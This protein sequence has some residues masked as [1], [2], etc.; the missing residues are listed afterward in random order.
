[1][2]KMSAIG[3]IAEIA[4][5]LA[6][7]LFFGVIGPYGTAQEP[8][9]ERYPFWLFVMVAG[10]LIGIAVERVL[11]RWIAPDWRRILVTS[12]AMTP[13]V[14]AVVI[15][16]KAAIMEHHHGLPG[17]F[18]LNLLWQV[19]VISLV[20]MALRLVVQR[21]P[22]RIVESQ[23]IIAPPLPEVEARFR[24]RLSARR[25][26]ARLFALEAY[27]H[28]VRV[29]TDAGE[30]LLSLRFADAVAE[31]DGAHGYR[32]HRSWWVAA[33]AIKTARWRRGS[34]AVE[35]ADGTMAPISRSGAPI[36][37]TAGYLPR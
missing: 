14:T 6:F 21:P 4:L 27:D 16:A 18:L 11:R 31:L 15:G 5:L 37:R 20:A 32:I 35:L 26:T 36:L 10:G 12:L 25:R 28:Y 33:D 34:G 22:K 19:F 23:T 29:H 24:A 30:E 17:G 2:S 1:M 7:G 13:P 3:G 8:P 9:V